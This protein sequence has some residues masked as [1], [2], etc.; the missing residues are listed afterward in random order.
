MRRLRIASVAAA[1][2]ALLAIGTSAHANATTTTPHCSVQDG[3][4]ATMRS[5][6]AA[7]GT[8]YIKFIYVN[9][10]DD[11]CALTGTPG[12]QPV[13]GVHHTAVG[14]SSAHL[15][16]SGRGGVVVLHARGGVASTAFGVETALNYP[17][18]KCMPKPVDGVLMHFAGVRAFYLRL[19]ARA[20]GTL[21]CTRLQST[22][23]DAVTRG[24]PSG[25]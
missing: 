5:D 4:K 23:T 18:S 25:P 6:G 21:V 3:L 1:V 13:R 14:P 17:H 24:T 19:P 10:D 2:M 15:H 8:A 12:V 16:V 7:A 11:A 9:T 22:T 20:V